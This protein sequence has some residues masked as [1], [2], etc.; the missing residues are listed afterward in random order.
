MS[1]DP[2]T[3]SQPRSFLSRLIVPAL[4][5]LFG[6]FMYMSQTQENPVTGEKQH[7]AFSPDQEIRLGLESAPQMSREMGGELPASDPR[8]QEVQKMGTLLVN[9]TIAK[10]SP[11]KF[12]FHVLADKDTV[13]AF[14]LPGGQVFITLGLLNQLQNEAQLA[15]VLGHEMG[16]VIER[17]TAQQMSKS[18][19]GQFFIVAVGAAASDPE[20]YGTNNSA[21]MIA[22]MVNQMIQLRYS[23]GDES[24]A[25]VWGLKLMS[26]AGY[27][28]YEM[29]KVM[30]ILKAAGG[31][32]GHGPSFFQT[33]PDPDLRI[34]QIKAYLKAHPPQLNLQNGKS[35][36][37]ILQAAPP[38]SRS[39][40]RSWKDILESLPY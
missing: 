1:Y 17:H 29:I 11:W 37:E 35:L 10:K 24:E 5:L 32:E 36:R 18:Q 33:H 9:T 25:D 15:G 21:A 39:E 38:S 6:L 23:R 20:G 28:P 26:Q 27:N 2:N 4:I 22:G 40:E 16:H 7:V 12:A 30:E 3:P 19:L 14:A 8:V 34:E 31:G 13:N